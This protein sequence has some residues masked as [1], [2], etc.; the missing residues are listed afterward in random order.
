MPRLTIA[1]P[2][3]KIEDRATASSPASWCHDNLAQIALVN[4]E[5]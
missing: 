2:R 4:G 3:G 1:T 5:R